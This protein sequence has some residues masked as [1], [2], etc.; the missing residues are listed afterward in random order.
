MDLSQNKNVVEDN[1][2]DGGG[3]VLFMLLPWAYFYCALHAVVHVGCRN[4]K[5]MQPP[6]V[7]QSNSVKI[8]L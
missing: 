6:Y 7:L 4:H 3:F 8:T 1:S 5:R 2:F